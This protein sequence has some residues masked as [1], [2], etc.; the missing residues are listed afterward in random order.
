MTADFQSER[1]GQV[2]R[3]GY[4]TAEDVQFLRQEVF[5]DG[6]VCEAELGQLL[7]LA[8]RAPDGDPAWSDFFGEAA[9]DFYLREEIPHDYIT[10]REFIDL[11]TSVTQ[12][13]DTVSPLVLS[14]LI[15]LLDDATATPPKMSAFIAD[16]I[17]AT[18]RGR[19]GAAKITA[20]DVHLIRRYLYAGGGSKGI[21]IS[22][23]EAELLFDLNDLTMA[24]DNDAAWSELFVKAVAN[25][26]MGHIGYSAP[27]REEALAQWEWMNDQ[28]VNVA[29]FFTRMVSGGFGAL[30]DAYSRTVSGDLGP[31]A[32]AYEKVNA[33]REELIQERVVVTG[34]EADWLAERIGRDGVLDDNE[35]AILAYMREIEGDLPD[36]LSALLNQAA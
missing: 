29:G 2:G 34:S 6:V 15:K 21:A 23:A 1:L 33:R 16:Q 20:R 17:R 19:K 27:S 36:K 8:E 7:A 5:A 10:E 4:V 28:S 25:H 35:R 14:M 13:N 24:A 22:R 3:N 9:G 32:S 30:R 11:K 12:Y 26:L 31:E 18:I